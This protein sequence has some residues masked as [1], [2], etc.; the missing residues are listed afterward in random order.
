MS[1]A[2]D[3]QVAATH[4]RGSAALKKPEDKPTQAETAPHRTEGF[5]SKISLED[6]SPDERRKLTAQWLSTWLR[7]G[8]TRHSMN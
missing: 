4:A 7:E 5:S 6:M 1:I 3:K 8:D 2:T